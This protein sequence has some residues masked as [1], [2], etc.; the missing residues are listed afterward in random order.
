[1]KISLFS[2]KSLVP[3]KKCQHACENYQNLSEDEKNKKQEYGRE[4]YKN[5]LED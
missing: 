5:L 3:P 2:S 4:H 1:M